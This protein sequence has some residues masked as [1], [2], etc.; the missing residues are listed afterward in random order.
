MWRRDRWRDGRRVRTK[1][2]AE[3]DPRR[4]FGGRDT[5][6]GTGEVTPEVFGVGSEGH[7]VK[8]GVVNTSILIG[9]YNP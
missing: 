4:S 6:R 9:A 7:G 8:R 2:V 1:G 5:R 3:G